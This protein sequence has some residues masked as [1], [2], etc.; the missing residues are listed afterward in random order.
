MFVFTVSIMTQVLHLDHVNF[1]TTGQQ[2]RIWG[3][4]R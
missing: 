1:Q 3:G 4:E 2:K